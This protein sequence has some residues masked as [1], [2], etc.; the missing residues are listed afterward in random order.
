[1]EYA[2]GTTGPDQ[3]PVGDSFQV[4]VVC[5]FLMGQGGRQHFQMPNAWRRVPGS[6]NEVITQP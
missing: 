6:A 1:M 2:A 4:T 3:C 5:F